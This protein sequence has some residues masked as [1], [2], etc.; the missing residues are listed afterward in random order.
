MKETDL[1]KPVKNMFEPFGYEVYSEVKGKW[2]GKRAD[3]VV[4]KENTLMAIELKTS[5]TFQLID[6]ARF[7]L[8]YA[9][10]VYIA[11]PKSKKERSYTA[12]DVL[13][14]LGIGLIS[15]DYTK[16]QR[17]VK[18]N[19]EEVLNYSKYAEIELEP[20]QNEVTQRNRLQFSN[21]TEEHKT[22]A[23]G[24]S[25]SDSKYVTD[26]GLLMND[27]YAYLR[28]ELLNG[29]NDGWVTH[30]DIYNYL[31]ENSRE[32][33]KRHYKGK[34]PQNSLKQAI[35]K[36]ENDDIQTIKMS[37]KWYCRIEEHSNKYK[38]LGVNL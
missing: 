38:N 19:K 12:M 10:Y 32:S 2:Y 3:M 27:V 1:F 26:Y 20:K 33:V 37:G 28:E 22:W 34:Q 4:T 9:D 6:Q 25:T 18:R 13:K 24:G 21:L 36:Y 16:Y 14:A 31:Q 30:H 35:I 23:S 17:E 8:K 15:V 5:L 29:V 7:W 11:V